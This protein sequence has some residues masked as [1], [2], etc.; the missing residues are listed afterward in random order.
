MKL[1]KNQVKLFNKLIPFIKKKQ[2]D[3]KF[4]VE[5]QAG[6]GKTTTM[7][8][9][10]DKLMEKN[11]LEK[12]NLFFIA[13]TNAA[14]KVLYKT[15]DKFM[16]NNPENH[17][18]FSIAVNADNNVVFNTIH[19]FFKSRQQFD[20][21]GNQ[22]FE[23]D[24]KK[25][26]LT[27]MIKEQI[28]KHNEEP[29][30]IIRKKHIIIIDECSMLDPQK[31]EMFIKLLE[32]NKFIRII[33][34]GDRNQLSY[35]R[36]NIDNID[37][38]D[39]Y[40]SPVFTNVQQT[41]LLKGNERSNDPGITKIINRSKKCVINSKYNF[42]LKKTDLSQN[43]N[44]IKEDELYKESVTNFIINENPKFISYS[45]KRRDRLN[46]Y[47]RDNKYDK[48]N[49]ID[50]Y[51][52]LENENII[53]ES[54]YSIEGIMLYY[55][56]DEFIVKNVKYD[57]IDN[58]QF[59]NIFSKTFM[60]Q[61]ITLDD[62]RE[63]LQIC[64]S[65]IKK[66]KHIIDILKRCVKHFFLHDQHNPHFANIANKCHM[67]DNMKTSFKCF[68]KNE[69]VCSDCFKNV[70]KYIKKRFIC[71]F[72]EC[73]N[74]HNS[75]KDA[76]IKRPETIKKK[77]L[78]IMYS[79]IQELHDRYNLPV[80]YSYCITCFKSQGSSYPNVIIDYKNIYN[81]NRYSINNLTRSMYVAKS[82]TQ[83]KL[84]FLNYFYH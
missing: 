38:E 50:R 31:Y 79:D 54:N 64:K 12:Y 17:R 9:T 42:K 70:Y 16:K 56:T 39:E 53:F 11:F 34:M 37:N 22:F 36:E 30:F 71:Q 59:F 27:D 35:V 19:S 65:Q 83:N 25:T 51:L 29:N 13:P 49:Y 28:K 23:L 74:D 69:Q 26:V 82:R 32:Y 24:W 84:W 1:K 33:F 73:F 47:V 57:I 61:K 20:E 66:F 55:N 48:H 14:K 62:D 21:D 72:C 60:F 68:G 44:I 3:R 18:K 76:K 4:L 78:D 5:G 7:C 52:F 77:I 75:C 40:L 58:I 2:N 63:L 80:K 6:S 10:I 41:F 8:Y 45:N 46:S 43:V 67:C 15:I 81:C